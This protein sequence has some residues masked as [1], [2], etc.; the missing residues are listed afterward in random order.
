MQVLQVL[1]EVFRNIL[2][3]GKDNDKDIIINQI[4]DCYDNN[5]YNESDVRYIVNATSKERELT[6]YIEEKD[7]NHF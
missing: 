2:L 7:Y 5:L 6:N 3:F 4:K 1:K